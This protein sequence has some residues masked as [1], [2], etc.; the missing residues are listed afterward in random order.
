[1]R[2]MLVKTFLV[3]A[4]LTVFTVGTSVVVSARPLSPAEA[5]S[6]ST[7]NGFAGKQPGTNLVA[8]VR[9]LKTLLTDPG[10]GFSVLAPQVFV[11]FP[12]MWLA[13]ILGSRLRS[14]SGRA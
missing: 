4:A 11:V 7:D 3:A 5:A 12:F 1:M 10:F 13:A 14:V 2:S 8:G 6:L 9:V